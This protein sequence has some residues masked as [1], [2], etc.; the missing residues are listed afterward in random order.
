MKQLMKY[1]RPYLWLM[2]LTMF[3]KLAGAALELLIPYLME[4]ILDEVVP[5]REQG[6]IYIYGIL[7]LLCGVLCRIP[8]YQ[9]Y[10]QY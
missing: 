7:M 6:K 10:L 1:I 5:A 2:G 9:R 4:I 3:I 8:A